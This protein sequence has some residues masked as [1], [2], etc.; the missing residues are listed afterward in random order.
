MESKSL[1]VVSQSQETFSK[2]SS[3]TTPTGNQGDGV[4]VRRQQGLQ[5][6]VYKEI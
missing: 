2:Q 4:T 6:H 1:A 5:F 3:V